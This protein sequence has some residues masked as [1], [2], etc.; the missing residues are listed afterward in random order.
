MNV[1]YDNGK[2]EFHLRDILSLV[3]DEQKADMIQELACEDAII[4]HISDQIIDKFTENISSGYSNTYAA[5]E[6][7][8]NFPLDHAWRRVA[9]ASGDIAKREIERLEEALKR[10]EKQLNQTMNELNR[11]KFNLNE[12]GINYSKW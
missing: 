3:S 1:N 6:P 11:F 10:R 8:E 2:I 12:I 5:V 4:K 7:D 9:K